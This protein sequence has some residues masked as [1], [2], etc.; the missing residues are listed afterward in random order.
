MRACRR[1][2]VADERGALGCEG[3]GGRGQGTGED[4]QI[5]GVVGNGIMGMRE[6]QNRR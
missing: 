3:T 6:E 5:S 2:K 4:M 1:L